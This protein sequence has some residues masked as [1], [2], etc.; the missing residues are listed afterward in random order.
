MKPSPFVDPGRVEIIRSGMELATNSRHP[1]TSLFPNYC[2]FLLKASAPPLSFQ[3]ASY[4][5]ESEVQALSLHLGLP[6]KQVPVKPHIPVA[7]FPEELL[8]KWLYSN[9]WLLQTL[10]RGKGEREA[11]TC[12]GSCISN[13]VSN[14]GS[15]I[16]RKSPVLLQG[17]G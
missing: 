4:C 17:T 5:Q 9:T 10:K 14:P 11:C 6:P 13:A 12:F 7:V 1:T 3:A 8:E 16:H 15:L 2:I